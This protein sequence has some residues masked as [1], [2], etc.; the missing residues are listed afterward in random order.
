MKRLW[1]LGLA[2]AA[3]SFPFNY[4]LDLLERDLPADFVEGTFQVRAGGID[5]N[6]KTLGPVP[7]SYTPDSRVSLSGASLEYRVCFTSETPGASFSGSLTY[8]AYLAGDE[9]GLLDPA[10]LVAQGIG[11]VA[12]LNAG[13]VCVSGEASLSAGQLQAVASGRFYVSARISGDATSSQEA[14]IRY[15]TEV[16]RLRLSG[17]VRP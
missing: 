7:V 17:T 15:R 4:T 16:L 2:L 3:C 1:F 14:T 10:N 13:P 5:P 6:P 9:A 11:G 12:G 8:A